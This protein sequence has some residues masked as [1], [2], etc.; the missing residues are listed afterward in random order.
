[1][2]AEDGELRLTATLGVG[3]GG[4]CPPR[5]LE[6]RP[7]RRA[8]RERA[9]AEGAL[10]RA[11]ALRRTGG[12]ASCR[13]AAAR[14]GEA[15]RRF[16]A[17]GLPRRR[18][19]ALEGLGRLERSCRD[20]GAALLALARAAPLLAGDAAAE[21]AVR[22]LLGEIHGAKGE[23]DPA[24]A[25]Y[26]RARVLRQRI[27]DRAG[28]A[29]TANNLGFALDLRGRYDE[30]ATLLDRAIALRRAGDEPCELANALLNRGELHRELG[31]GEGA[32]SC[33]AEA[34]ASARRARDCSLEAAILNA[35]G[36]AAL[37]AGQPEAA[38]SPL[39]RSLTL[40]RPGERGQAV[41]LTSLGVAF[42]GLGRNEDARR[43][44]AEAAPIFARL[45]D[46]REEARSLGNIGWLETLTGHD[47]DALGDFARAGDLFA[48]LA[49]APERAW[50][51]RGRAA[52]LRHRGDLR[53]ARQAMEE[54]LRAVERHRFQQQGYGT[55]AAFFSTQQEAYDSLID[56][57]LAMH[58]AAPQAG[59]DAE[60]LGV[61]E[62]ALARSLL[63]GLAASGTDLGTGASPALA[64]RERELE[65]EVDALATRESRLAAA[66]G[67]RGRLAA[68]LA[69]QRD[70][71]DR[72]RAEFRAASPRYAA[73]T[74]PRPWSA[75]EIR[76]R[77]LDR[78]TLLLEY[79]LG[80][81]RSVLWA[82][83]RGSLHTFELA[84]REEIEAVA[85]RAC[86]LAARSG[87][88][89]AAGSA[90]AKLAELSRRLL[91]PAAAL[92]PG[93]RL[94]VVG[95]GILQRL[96][97]AALPE[98]G[99]G[100]PLVAHHEIVLLPSI[101]VL[102]EL[103]REAA[104]RRPAPKTLWVLA[105]PATGG[106]F[107]PL[108]YARQEAAAILALAP[109][110]GRTLVAGPA[111][112]RAAV[113]AGDLRDY[114]FLH[115]AAHG[116][117]DDPGGGRLVLARVDE[118]GRPAADGFLHLADIYGL[119]LRADL[120]VLSA[121][122]SALGQEVRGEGLVGMT[123]GF[124]YAGAE[125]VLVSLWNVDDQASVEL[126]ERFYRGVLRE[127]LSPA[128]ALQRAQDAVRRE[129]RWRAPYYWAGFVLE[130]DWRGLAGSR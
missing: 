46:S 95:D 101:S 9:R 117:F 61:G 76:R 128:A 94:V 36:L 32:R 37:Y 15:E 129:T 35:L 50:V 6:R 23:L 5:L 107:P 53:G 130:G 106:A 58:R 93:K 45:G 91:A 57:L 43:A 44:Y 54:A 114:R 75:A 27:G 96:P 42:R 105:D 11:H 100:G 71:L 121:C 29:V 110:G 89:K 7:A 104:G 31:E 108:P 41:T 88:K 17:L 30:A 38:L 79:R 126:M 111:A 34:L 22:Q 40:R 62:R 1:M 118:R 115:F 109:P 78:D 80:A 123:R 51:L 49:D 102:G 116:T 124:F 63:D 3:P 98:P 69:H 67:Q 52:A 48:R 12:A 83:T 92:L 120:A 55:R 13:E 86:E 14:Y 73:L 122:Q 47:D 119:D 16:A 25:E 60:A 103:R 74:E 113:V 68:E 72:V 59:Y 8:D 21:A 10:A 56:L 125:R 90:E 18:A 4:P 85:R 65:A 24:I 26:R 64:R 112:S 77:L 84:G 97:F 33:F 70:E 81:Q 66:P 19:E 87:G 28:E 82:A 2:A 99:G 39:Q 127:G 20:D